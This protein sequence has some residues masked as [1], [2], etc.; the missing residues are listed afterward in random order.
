ML[1]NGNVDVM[2]QP[3]LQI[4]NI[5]FET[6]KKLNRDG[7]LTDCSFTRSQNTITLDDSLDY[8]SSSVYILK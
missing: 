4:G 8:M 5:P 6:V 1:I 3:T 2:E 7:Q